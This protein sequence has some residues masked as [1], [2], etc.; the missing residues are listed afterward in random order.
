MMAE[1]NDEVVYYSAFNKGFTVLHA[2]GRTGRGGF[3][4]GFHRALACLLLRQVDARY[5]AH[6]DEMGDWRPAAANERQRHQQ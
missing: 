4:K 3:R 6:P 5:V 2:E 1:A